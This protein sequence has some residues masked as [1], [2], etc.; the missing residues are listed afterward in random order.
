MDVPVVTCVLVVPNAPPICDYSRAAPVPTS[1]VESA[2]DVAMRRGHA[3][4]PDPT[5]D[6]STPQLPMLRYDSQ[7]T[8][9][10]DI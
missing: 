9:P 10:E 8:I 3:T 7:L 4:R 5:D 6:S 1:L 2:P